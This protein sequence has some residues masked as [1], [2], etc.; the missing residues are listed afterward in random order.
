MTD[1]NDKNDPEIEARVSVR[2]ATLQR[3]LTLLAGNSEGPVEV[4]ELLIQM[5]YTAALS[6]DVNPAVI[7]EMFTRMIDHDSKLT[8]EESEQ[9]RREAKQLMRIC[10]QRAMQIRT[11]SARVA[12][13]I[14]PSE[15]Q[16]RTQ[17]VPI[18][19]VIWCEQCGGVGSVNATSTD[20]ATSDQPCPTCNKAGAQ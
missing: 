4:I 2:I 7:V 19:P 16:A 9:N 10:Y 15:P 3:G 6:C 20:G 13:Q 17:S 12:A 8:T 14:A 18:A 1:K 11:A 5:L